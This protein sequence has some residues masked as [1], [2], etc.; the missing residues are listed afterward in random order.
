MRFSNRFYSNY[1][2]ITWGIFEKIK[3]FSDF[4]AVI[5]NYGYDNA[6]IEQGKEL[7]NEFHNYHHLYLEKRQAALSKVKALEAQFKTVFTEY[8]NLVKR[9]RTE[10]KNDLETK[11]ILGAKGERERSKTGFIDQAINFY[12]MAMKPETFSKIQGFGIT[13]EILKAGLQ[14]VREFY[15]F[16]I[17]YESMRGECQELVEKRDQ[18]Y[19]KFRD[20]MTA[21][22]TTCKV[23]YAGNL[24]TLEKFGM[25]MRNRPKPQPEEELPEIPGA[26]VISEKAA[27]PVASLEHAAMAEEENKASLPA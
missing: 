10:L 3:N 16:R 26:P 19:L 25:F 18:S 4:L 12:N 6:R 17:V 2:Q 11:T 23:A 9:L 27:M 15:D 22:I 5:V 21:F 14:H 7:Y 1:L 8:A 13:Q 20:W 24:Q